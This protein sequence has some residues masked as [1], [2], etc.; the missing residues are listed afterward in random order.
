MEHKFFYR[1]IIVF[2]GK[3]T[4]SSS[5]FMPHTPHWPNVALKI[6][7]ISTKGLWR[8]VIYS[9]YGITMNR[10]FIKAD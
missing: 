6:N 3:G 8:P 9:A 5:K 4:F 1:L 7:W 10:I 2:C